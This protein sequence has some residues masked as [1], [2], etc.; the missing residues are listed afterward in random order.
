MWHPDP[1]WKPLPGGMGPSTAGVWLDDRF[2]S[3]G[4]VVI[5]RLEAPGPH[6]P[7]ELTDPRHFAYWRR[8]S[9]VA[10]SGA[11]VDTPGL[12]APALVGA[13]EDADGITLRQAHVPTASLDERFVARSL[14]RFAGAALPAEPW[15]AT[16]QLRD[17][18]A[19]VERRGGWRVLARTAVADVAARIWERR[20]ELL[21][22][23][24][25]IAPVAQ[26]G[27]PVP[28][29]LPGYLPAK[30]AGGDGV[31]VGVGVGEIVAIDWSSLGLGPAGADLGYYSLSAANGLD[32]LLGDYLDG[33][34]PGVASREDVAAAARITAVYTVL[35]RADWALSRIAGGEGA[36]AGK[37]RHPAVAP[38]LRAMQR[39]YPQIEALL[40]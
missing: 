26:H 14:G 36:L 18:I 12:R 19:R 40:Y 21:E 2:G 5:K 33:L 29:N 27:D 32:A 13:E 31:G 16:H 9:D 38:Y 25:A 30:P 17:R 1:A 22:R 3:G 35:T 4:P 34:G 7:G 6:D 20:A 23:L 15:L 10:L 11:V 24:D 8:A 28:G 37:F 39:Q